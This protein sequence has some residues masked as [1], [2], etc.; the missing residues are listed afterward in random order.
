MEHMKKGEKFMNEIEN[1]NEKTF[2]SIK[3]FDKNRNEYWEALGIN[4]TFRI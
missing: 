2:E 4:V 3:H 1:Y